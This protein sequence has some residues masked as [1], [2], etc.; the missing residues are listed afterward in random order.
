MSNSR[1]K[2]SFSFQPKLNQSLIRNEQ[3]MLISFR[4]KRKMFGR[5]LLDNSKE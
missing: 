2:L 3:I 4:K 5:D 1:K